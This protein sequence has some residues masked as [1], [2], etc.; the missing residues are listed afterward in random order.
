[1]AGV[2]RVYLTLIASASCDECDWSQSVVGDKV[3]S[4]KAVATFNSAVNT[5]SKRRG[6]DV[7]VTFVRV[8]PGKRS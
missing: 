6:H 8:F 7:R 3:L 1:M 4:A 5:H 2:K